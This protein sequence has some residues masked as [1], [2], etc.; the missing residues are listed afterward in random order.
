MDS[1]T[2]IVGEILFDPAMDY[3]NENDSSALF[4]IKC[5]MTDYEY[6]VKAYGKTAT[7]SYQYLKAGTIVK[8]VGELE[9][10][11]DKV[12]LGIITV[13]NVFFL[14][15]NDN[16]MYVKDSGTIKPNGE[17]YDNLTTITGK[18]LYHPL[19]D[20][21][22][23]NCIFILKN[24]SNPD[25]EYYV[26]FNIISSA[27]LKFIEKM[28]RNDILKITGDLITPSIKK[29]PAMMVG[30]FITLIEKHNTPTMKEAV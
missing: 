18:L 16:R 4:I 2:S 27:A 30:Y 9:K 21:T 10:E 8:V 6:L 1:K 5:R 29:T 14:N 7:A 13:T 17:E 24:T 3:E 23:M 12:K 26:T 22:K 25:D 11:A 28:G 20:K 19:I 15:T